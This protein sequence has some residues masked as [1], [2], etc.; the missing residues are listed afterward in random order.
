MKRVN[1]HQALRDWLAGRGGR[2]SLG[3]T[4]EYMAGLAFASLKRLMQRL[5][6]Q[7]DIKYEGG[8]VVLTASEFDRHGNR[9]Q[10]QT[11]R[12]IA[13]RGAH[14]LCKRQGTF[15]AQALYQVCESKFSLRSIRYFISAAL[16]A[17]FFDSAGSGHYRL[18]KDAP[19]RWSAPKINIWGKHKSPISNAAKQ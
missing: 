9:Q 17:G 13:W 4:Y 11:L 1:H 2:A 18:A 10:R 8:Q 6:A 16:S 12:V 19:D 7:G 14:Q 15:S 5:E 3:D